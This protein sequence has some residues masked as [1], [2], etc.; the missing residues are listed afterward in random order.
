MT[1]VASATL[2]SPVSALEAGDI[3]VELKPGGQRLNLIPGQTTTG[4]IYVHNK[5]RLDFTFTLSARP[6]RV[7][8]EDYD[9]DFST[10]T[11][12]T[13]LHNWIHFKQDSYRL[14]AGEEL[15]VPFSV[16]APLNL[17]SGGQYAAV[18]VE[19]RDS[20]DPDASVR[21]VNQVASLLFG[22][23]E[24]ETQ[25]GG[26][27]MAHSLPHFL[28]SSPFTASMTVKNDGN[29]DFR[30]IET[31]T[32]YDFFTGREV[33]GTSNSGD[34]QSPAELRATIL[35]ATT[36]TSSVTWEGAPQLGIFRAVQTINFLDQA[37]TYEQIVFLCPIWLAGAV[38]VLIVLALIWLVLRI[39][40]RKHSRPQA[41]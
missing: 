38:V 19:T 24:G 23:V 31:L 29:I 26:V 13:K 32:I 41:F 34:D 17:P 33:F 8:N 40:R 25:I 20:A 3:V 6:Y 22:Q 39:R 21:T 5:G 16:E 10:E 30:A 28:L 11:D 4:K 35:P 14:A 37:Y 12:Y 18:I 1:L 2:P 15:E 9:P 36:R 7:T 27:L